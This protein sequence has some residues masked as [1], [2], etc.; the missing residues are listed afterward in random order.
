VGKNFEG[1][2]DLAGT[3]CRV[4]RRNENPN[5]I[6]MSNIHIITQRKTTI[7]HD[8]HQLTAKP[9]K[10]CELLNFSRS[11]GKASNEEPMGW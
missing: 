8:A 6:N 7:A 10:E 1:R 3:S 11:S 9:R 2:R 4:A 5:L